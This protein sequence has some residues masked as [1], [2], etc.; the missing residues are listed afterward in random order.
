MQFYLWTADYL[1]LQM[2]RIPFVDIVS[3][4]AA[5]LL[6]TIGNYMNT[7]LFH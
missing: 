4:L 2:M 7:T 3:R 5:G 6:I 1:Q